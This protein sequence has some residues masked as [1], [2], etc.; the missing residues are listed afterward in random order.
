MRKDKAGGLYAQCPEM[1]PIGTM[2]GRNPSK[3]L[4]TSHTEQSTFDLIHSAC[5]IRPQ[6][7]PLRMNY[8]SYRTMLIYSVVI[9]SDHSAWE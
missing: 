4:V 9:L 2:R 5:F 7:G 8:S 6:N 3:R 1:P